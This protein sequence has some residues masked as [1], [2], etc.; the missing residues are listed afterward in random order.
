MATSFGF[1]PAANGDPV[2]AWN[3]PF[4]SLRKIETEPLSFV[5]TKSGRE[6]PFRSATSTPPG[7]A[8]VCISTRRK[9]DVGSIGVP[10]DPSH[11]QSAITA[12]MAEVRIFPPNA[13]PQP[14]Y[15]GTK[16]LSNGAPPR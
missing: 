14:P 7:D 10:C 12:Q 4:P 6:S 8:P 16:N 1:G 9:C 15:T 5:T 13:T 3:R 2:G 11:E